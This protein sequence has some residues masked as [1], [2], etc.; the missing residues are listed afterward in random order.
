MPR[1]S[2][3]SITIDPNVRCQRIY[4]VE[5]SKKPIEQLETVG[6]KLTRQ[7]AIHMARVLLVVSQD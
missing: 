7:Q 2:P 3:R 1:K 4:P 6:I 5:A